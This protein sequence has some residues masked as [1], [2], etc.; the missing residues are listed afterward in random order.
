MG[1]A[2]GK[3]CLTWGRD[4]SLGRPRNSGVW[5][6]KVGLELLEVASWDTEVLSRTQFLHFQWANPFLVMGTFL[7]SAQSLAP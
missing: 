4:Q 2:E 7:P 6:L 5:S 3:S 1:K